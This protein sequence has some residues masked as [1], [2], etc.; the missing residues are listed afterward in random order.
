M[1]SNNNKNNARCDD[2][3]DLNVNCDAIG[4]IEKNTQPYRKFLD[5]W[6]VFFLVGCCIEF[7]TNK[8]LE[9]FNGKTAVLFVSNVLQHTFQMWFNSS[10]QHFFSFLFSFPLSVSLT[11]IHTK[12]FE[13]IHTDY[14]FR[15]IRI[16][17]IAT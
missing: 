16:S 17:I 1:N 2:S 9:K 11:H 4:S 3:E 12:R 5:G 8:P 14:F 6:T 13:T 15:S 10:M 7:T